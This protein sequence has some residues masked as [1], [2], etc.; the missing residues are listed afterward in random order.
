MYVLADKYD[1][2]SLGELAKKNFEAVAAALSPL[3]GATHTLPT[4]PVLDTIPR[5]Y[6]ATG[7]HN[8]AL[9]DAV[10]EYTRLQ[11]TKTDSSYLF[12]SRIAE[13]FDMVPEFA[14]DVSRSWLRVPHLGYCE[15][16]DCGRVLRARERK[17]LCDGCGGYGGHPGYSEWKPRTRTAA[18]SIGE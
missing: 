5:I 17:A 11:R 14:A 12:T 9:R 1:I 3:Y 18:W 15:G 7:E 6:A 13:I 4:F 10:V 16:E 2:P 8:R